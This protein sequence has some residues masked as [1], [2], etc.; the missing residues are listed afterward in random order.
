MAISPGRDWSP[1]QGEAGALRVTASSGHPS[2]RQRYA[3]REGI[4][5]PVDEGQQ[6]RERRFLD[7]RA[8][9]LES[10]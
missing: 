6:A 1:M 8:V 10:A 2:T 7:Y 4:L 3:L 5:G 9:E